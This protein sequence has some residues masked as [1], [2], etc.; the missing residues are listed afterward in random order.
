MRPKRIILVRHGESE[1]NLD[2][3]RYHTTQDFALKLTPAGVEQAKQAG[4]QIK[5]FLGD[6][7][8]YVY[9]SPFFRSKS[10]Q[11]SAQ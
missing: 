1:G 9:L 10:A 4:I 3:L 7:K 5:E 8:I 11:S 6:E 2:R